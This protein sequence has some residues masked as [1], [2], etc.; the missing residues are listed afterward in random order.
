LPEAYI[1][2]VALWGADIEV[3]EIIDALNLD[4]TVEALQSIRGYDPQ[5]ASWLANRGVRYGSIDDLRLKVDASTLAKLPRSLAPN[6]PAFW[7]PVVNYPDGH[8]PMF[9]ALQVRRIQGEPRYLTVKFIA[10]PLA[11]IALPTE[12]RMDGLRFSGVWLTEGILKAEVVAYRLGVVAVGAL[13][14]GALRQALSVV[15]KVAIRWHKDANLFTAPIVL[16]PDNDAKTNLSVARAFWEAAKRLQ[17]DGFPVYFAVWSPDHKGVDDALLAGETPTV[18]SLEAWLASLQS[19]IRRELLKVNV[20]SRLILDKETYLLVDLPESSV[21]AQSV[22]GLT[23]EVAQRKGAWLQALS[24]PTRNGK[25]P[26]VVDISPAGSGKTYAAASLRLSELRRAGIPAKRLIH[27]LPEVKRP[28]VEPLKRY[29]LF[30]G[31]DTLCSY[32]ERLQKVE[33]EGLTNVGKNICRHCPARIQCIY[34]KQKRSGGRRYWLMSWQSYSPKEGDV[35]VL[36]EISRLPLWRPF[37]MT[38][39]QLADLNAT[40]DRYGAPQPIMDAFKKLYEAI[41]HRSHLSHDEVAQLF[42]AVQQDD[43]RNFAYNILTLYSDIRKVREWIFRKSE[44]RP[45]WLGWTQAIVDIFRDKRV[46]QVWAE[47]G[48]LKVKVLDKKVRDIVNK[49][50]AIL[51]LDA[52]ANKDEIEWMLGT[53]VTVLRSDEPEVFPKVYQIPLGALSHR[54]SPETYKRW[55]MMVK[56]CLERLQ[57]MENL[58]MDNPIGLLTHKKGYEPARQVFGENATIGWF[59][60]DDRATNVYYDAGVRVLACVGVPYRNISDISAERLKAGTRRRAFRKAKLD[61]EGN[62][63]VI[64]REFA[65]PELAAAVRMEAHNAYLQA[66]GRLRQGRRSEQCY[67]VVFDAEPLPEIL[68]PIV[69]PPWE[70]LPEEIWQD[71]QR[72]RRKGAEVINALR[73]KAA[74]ERLAKA[75][76]AVRLYRQILN[77]D[78]HP[79]WLAKVLGVHRDTARK[80]LREVSQTADYIVENREGIEDTALSAQMNSALCDTLED[81]IRTFLSYGYPLPARALARRFGTHENKV[82]RLARRLAKAQLQP[83]EPSPADASA[84]IPVPLWDTPCPACGEPLPEPER[85]LTVC[86]GCGRIWFVSPEGLK[87]L[88]DP[89]S[90]L[91]VKVVCDRCGSW[92]RVPLDELMRGELSCVICGE[93]MRP[94]PE[95]YNLSDNLTLTLPASQPAPKHLCPLCGEPIEPEPNGTAVCVGCGRLFQWDGASWRL[96]EPITLRG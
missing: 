73:Q 10:T 5:L 51:I 22:D 76:E 95:D 7:L 49:V 21:R 6:E 33:A 23:Y 67:L 24:C 18:V 77:E 74:A 20:C 53:E 32:W 34:Y 90:G 92:K 13:G 72:H 35:L 2:P 89:E 12:D 1:S 71:W 60:R 50:A 36:D 61:P 58:P 45:A 78:P 88:P 83:T 55:F 65:D 8:N 14:T 80:V 68:N 43:W 63:G 9:T 4:A 16:A 37:Y 40:L 17:I 39:D 29:R 27:I 62:W 25:A 46:G 93:P 19:R 82:I 57:H 44:Q 87:P 15:E 94:E 96:A 79:S 38:Q 91:E 86:L 31:R 28:A 75:V 81:A 3:R 59:G 85:S 47:G 26:V 70:I 42:S 41:Q 56:L 48:M 84:N 66:A 11:H 54:A 52:T 30:Q 64:L 69:I